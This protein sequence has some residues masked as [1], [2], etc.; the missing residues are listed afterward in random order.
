MRQLSRLERLSLLLAALFFGLCLGYFLGGR[1]AGE[2]YRVTV[3]R[4]GDSAAASSSEQDSRP[5]SLLEGEVINVN[6][7]TAADLQRLPGIGEAKARAIL[8]WREE[9]GPFESPEDLME[10]SGI[11]P[12]IF[13]DIQAYVTVR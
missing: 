9:H 2:P 8:D 7:A 6:T 3:T 10:V 13:E 11:G 4:D 5:V 1:S 12:G